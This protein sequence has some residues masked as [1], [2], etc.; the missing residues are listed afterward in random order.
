MNLNVEVPLGSVS[1]GFV[2]Y[3]ILRE[4][5]E[6][7]I[8]PNLFPIGGAV[9]LSSFD[10]IE[11]DFE[12]YLNSCI[13]KAPRSYKRSYPAFKLWHINQSQHSISNHNTHFTFHECDSLS[14][15][16]TNIL[17]NQ[18]NIIVSSNYSKGVFE[19]AGLTNCHVIPLGYD[20]INF[21]PTGKRAYADNVIA[22]SL[23]G[24][25]ELRKSTLQ[26]INLWCQK[27]GNNRE[28]ILNIHVYNT[29]LKPEDNNNL[30]AQ[31]FGGNKPFNVNI[32]PY[33]K[34]LTEVNKLYS[35]ATDIVIDMSK[36]EGFS[37]PSFHCVGLGKHA[38]IHNATALRDWA[39]PENAV[40]VESTGM[41]P[42]KDGVFFNDGDFNIGNWYTWKPEDF[43]IALDKAVERYRAAPLNKA[44]LE[45]KNKFTWKNTV[46]SILKVINN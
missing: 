24:K 46:D 36:A 14:E 34:T 31:A 26:V 1:F 43:N 23:T 38:V 10:Q 32:L 39:T 9:D 6:R 22:F 33:F 12:F 7:G 20:T 44:G 37:L 29:F 4:L 28:F 30:L 18:T 3:N 11:K 19:S 16:E 21:K 2:S 41:C 17:S 15:V 8:S 42:A 27:Y 5:Y 25:A 45:L 40:L 35:E 13:R